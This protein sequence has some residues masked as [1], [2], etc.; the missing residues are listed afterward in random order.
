MYGSSKPN[1]HATG[2]YIIMLISELLSIVHANMLQMIP[3][4]CFSLVAHS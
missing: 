1:I 4:A 2:F 3:L